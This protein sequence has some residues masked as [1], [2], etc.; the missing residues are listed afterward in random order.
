MYILTE[1]LL[2]TQVLDPY[3][4]FLCLVRSLTFIYIP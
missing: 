2:K 4:T 1:L 3:G